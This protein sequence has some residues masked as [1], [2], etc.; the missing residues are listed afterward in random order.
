MIAQSNGILIVTDV[1]DWTPVGN[2]AIFAVNKLV[3]PLTFYLYNFDTAAWETIVDPVI[4]DDAYDAT[5]WDGNLDGASKNALRDIIESLVAGVIPDADYGDITVSSS[6][7]VF[8]IDNNVVSLAKMQ[9][10]SSDRLLGRDT[11]GSGDPEE[12]AVGGGIEFTGSGGIQRSAL[13]GDVT[14]PAGSNTTTL[15]N[16]IVTNAKLATTATDTLLGRDT[17]GTGNVEYITLDDTLEFTGSLSIQRAAIGGDVVIAAGSNTALIP[18]DTI[19]HDKYQNIA[20]DKMLARTTAGSGNVEEID[21]SDYSQGLI[22]LASEAAFKAYVNLEIGTDVQAFDATLTALAGLNGTAGLIVETAADTFTKRTLTGT[23][24]EITVTNGDGSGGNPTISLPTTIDL[25]SK[26]SFAIPVSAAP[27]VNSDGEIAVDTTVTDFSHGVVK[28]FAT[29]ELAVITVPIAELTGMSDGDVIKYNATADEFQISPEGALDATLTALAGLDGT[30]GLVV[31]TA[32]DTFTKRTITGTANEISVGDGNGVSG[33][34]TISLPSTIDLGGK[35]SFEIPNSAAPTVDANGE[36]AVDTTIADMSHGLIKYFSTEE[37]AVIA[38][39]LAE[40]TGMAQGDVI[41]YD[42]TDD[43]FKIGPVPTNSGG[44]KMY[45]AYWSQSGTGNPTL[46]ATVVNDFGGTFTLARSSQGVYTANLTSA[47]PDANKFF[48]FAIIPQ[49]TAK[50]LMY[51]VRRTSA[52]EITLEIYTHDGT[53]ADIDGRI[54]VG[55][56]QYP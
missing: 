33:N 19:T 32:A 18:N 34:P 43:E 22:N 51:S 35:T 36:I 17:A 12:I 47:F 54:A 7:T 38:V 2:Q 50:P 27:T 10:I 48:P 16:N 37:C 41:Y 46:T 44:V 40:L 42:A 8:T 53:A 6:G 23:A 39:P 5:D 45:K 29:E 56:E 24:N 4:S 26:T 1:P 25:S 14:A 55:F 15:G 3:T 49:S 31:E 52:D 9:D 13:T 21:F 30:A 11:A 28:V 20:T